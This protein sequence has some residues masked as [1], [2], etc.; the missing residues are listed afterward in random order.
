MTNYA[1]RKT[2]SN[3][4]KERLY[5][6]LFFLIWPFGALLSTL[7]NMKGKHFLFIYTLFCILLCWNMDVRNKASYDDLSGI[8]D[9]FMYNNLTTSDFLDILGKYFSG[10]ADATRELYLYFMIWFTR[11]FSDNP[12]TFFAI[13]SLPYLFFQVKSLKIIIDNPKF[14]NGWIAFLFIFLFIMPRDII[15]VQNPRFTTALWICI[16]VIM[17]YYS[18]KGSWKTLLWLLLTPFIHSSF[19]F[20]IG[21]FTIGLFSKHFQ[22]ILM[23][24]VYISIPFSYMSTEFTNSMDISSIIPLPGS[25]NE[26][27]TS[28]LNKESEIISHGTG[29]LYWVPTMFDFL[30]TTAYLIIPILLWRKRELLN[31]QHK[32]LFSFYLFLFAIVNFLQPVPVLGTRFMWFVQILSIYMLFLAYGDNAKKFLIIIL[33]ANSWLIFNRYFYRGAV[34]RSVPTIIFYTPAPYIIYE[35]WGLDHIETAELEGGGNYH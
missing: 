12:H 27:V 28:Y 7:K 8:A 18:R 4:K 22:Y 15:T 9:I 25:L 16:Y 23:P 6:I 24:L 34:A 21:I 29:G 5:Y 2:Y 30:K 35:Y 32:S 14:H 31:I 1:F 17:K 33:I 26:W 20:F 11:L 3:S 19:W 13:C 10:H